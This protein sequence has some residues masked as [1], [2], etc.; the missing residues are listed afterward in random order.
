MS[1]EVVEVRAVDWR[2]ERRVILVFGEESAFMGAFPFCG[3]ERNATPMGVGC[4][5]LVR[6]GMSGCQNGS[7]GFGCSA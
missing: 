4:K 2:N 1:R 7:T 5:G 3:D 6:V